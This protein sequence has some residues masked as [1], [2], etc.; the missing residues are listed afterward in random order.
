MLLLSEGQVVEVW[1]PS[2]A[3]ELF[4]KCGALKEM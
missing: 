2:N 1:E 3:A 4:R